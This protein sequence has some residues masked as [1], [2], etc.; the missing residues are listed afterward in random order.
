MYSAGASEFGHYLLCFNEIEVRVQCYC[1]P[2]ILLHEIPSA[3][4]A[5]PLLSSA[6][7]T[8]CVADSNSTRIWTDERSTKYQE[9]SRPKPKT[10]MNWAKMTNKTAHTIILSH[11]GVAHRALQKVEIA[12]SRPIVSL[13]K[14]VPFFLSHP[15]HD[16]GCPSLSLEHRGSLPYP[17]R[18]NETLLKHLWLE[19]QRIVQYS[20]DDQFS[21]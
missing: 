19:A 5:F 11:T 9:S 18:P 1:P 16:S 17:S 12:I 13:F 4:C 10:W 2:V 15:L 3:F 20:S 8:E 21:Q 6:R 7:T 14:R